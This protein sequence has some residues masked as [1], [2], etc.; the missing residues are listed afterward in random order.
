MSEQ[1]YT[2]DPPGGANHFCPECHHTVFGVHY[3]GC[4]KSAKTAEQ[5]EIE[6]LRAELAEAKAELE[7]AERGIIDGVIELI[8]IEQK[9]MC[10]LYTQYAYG[11]NKVCNRLKL[12]VGEI[13][14]QPPTNQ[15]PDK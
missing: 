12:F 4:S 13:T 3:A 2:V 8:T 14:K 11:I 7:K 9:S 5:K 6:Q 15:E 1:T 10:N